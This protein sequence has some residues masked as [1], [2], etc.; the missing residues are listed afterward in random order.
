ML[1]NEFYS[2]LKLLRLPCLSIAGYTKVD[3]GD[4]VLKI[5]YNFLPTSCNA[6]T[7]I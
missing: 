2:L 7:A 5:A 4:G 1:F 6:I 3:H